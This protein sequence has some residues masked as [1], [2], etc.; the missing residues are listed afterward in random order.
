[1]FDPGINALSIVTRILPTAV[2][3]KNAVLYFP[4]NQE[5]PIAAS[6]SLTDENATPIRAEFDFRQTGPQSWDIDIETDSGR[7]TLSNGGA[8]MKVNDNTV[9]QATDR[10]YPNLYAHFATLVREKRVDVD[11]APLRLVADAFLCGKRVEVEPFV[12]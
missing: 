3:L 11:V 7:L 8:V 5:T 6:L 12:E 9:I 2:V 4:S 10:E 1:M